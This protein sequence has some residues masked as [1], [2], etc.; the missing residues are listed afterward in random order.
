[1]S[2]SIDV[3][4]RSL[5]K[6]QEELCGDKVEIL[7]TGDSDIVILA[8]GMGSGVKA[9]ILAT[10]TSKILGT[11]L[12]EG[13]AIESCVETI[14]RTLPVCKVR[15][16]AY[17]TFSI[18]QIFHSG[19]AYLAEFDNPSC[20]FIRDGKILDY[21]YKVREI[22]GK[23]IHEYRFQVKKNDCFVLMSDGVIYAGAGSILNMQ[24][25]TWEAMAEY[26]LNCT[27]KTLSA[28]RLAVLL[29]QACDELYEERPGD[30]T[31]VAVARVIERRIVNIF[32]GPPKDK[33]DDDRLMH[34]FMHCEGKKV[35]SGG[36][37]SNIA[38]RFLGKE[39]VTRAD[40]ADP[41]VPPVAEIEGIDL[42]TEGVLTLGKCL[43][44]LKKYANDEFDEEFFDELDADNG[45]SRLA[46]MLI[47]ECTELNLFVGTSVNKA[48]KNSE[49]SFDL[50]M[51]MN[52]VE[53]LIRIMEQIGRNVTVKYY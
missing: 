11:M 1:M 8:D 5:N 14:A 46:K 15:K 33:A 3:A 32:T 17:A 23:K 37:S 31:T 42:V 44:L 29:S 49:L 30:D 38:A 34:E 36:T 13:A 40:S 19:Q 51:R 22:E 50:S 43:K 7:K 27:K 28:S 4:W 47:E 6:Y 41:D 52:L 16:V 12:R 2:V 24:G 10:L 39:I 21:P 53:Q 9:N 18:L 35:V 25:W 20:V 48:H 45:A 26:T